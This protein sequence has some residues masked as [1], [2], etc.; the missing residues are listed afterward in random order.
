MAASHRRRPVAALV[1]AGAATGLAAMLLWPGAESRPSTGRG[2]VPAGLA[3]PSVPA[4]NVPSPAPLR[5]ER[6]A[7]TW[8][9]VR[10]GVVA[11]SGPSSRGRAV[12]HLTRRTPEGTPNPLLVLNRSHDR[13]GRVWLRVRLSTLP[14]GTTGWVPRE[15]VGGY[16]TVRTQLVVNIRRRRLTLLRDGRR[17]FRAAVGVGLPQWPTPRG[18][19]FI[20]NKLVRYRSPFYGPVAFGTSARSAELTDWPGGGFVGIHGTDRPDLVPGAV[21]HGC[22]RMRNR[23]I[24]RLSRLLLVGTPLRIV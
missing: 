8:T 2:A 9:T 15:V 6:H 11:R 12:A 20:R 19:F 7:S 4:L 1:A 16:R 13:R 21:S 18:R 22:I 23:D 5:T 3:A 24:L 17:V 14:N 10:E